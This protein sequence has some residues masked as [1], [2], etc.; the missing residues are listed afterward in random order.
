MKHE[1]LPPN[2]AELEGR[3]Q[4]RR[5]PEPSPE[6]RDRLL[7]SIVDSPAP[8]ADSAR[9]RRRVAAAVLVLLNIWLAVGNAGKFRRMDESISS[10]HQAPNR[11]GPTITIE[12]ESDQRFESFASGALTNLRPAPDAG[13]AG[14][15][16]FGPEE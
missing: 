12:S 11:R 2:L 16:L 9:W 7:R 6:F 1:P 8:P 5:L 10:L 4:Q 15:K 14:Q 3:F 13:V